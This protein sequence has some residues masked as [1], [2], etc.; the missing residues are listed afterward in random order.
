MTAPI[1]A[2]D[3]VA[4]ELKQQLSHYKIQVLTGQCKIV[5]DNVV[6]DVSPFTSEKDCRKLLNGMIKLAKAAETKRNQ[7]M[8]F[9]DTTA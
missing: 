5:A 6:T 8:F 7:T 9:G 2:I 4:L 3:K 1:F